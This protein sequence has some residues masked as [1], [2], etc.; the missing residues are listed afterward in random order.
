MMEGKMSDE[1]LVSL[2]AFYVIGL[3]FGLFCS[4]LKWQDKRDRKTARNVLSMFLWPIV[5]TWR[6]L[7]GLYRVVVDAIV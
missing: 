6:L 1:A 3:F 5:L 7:R 2:I 4:V